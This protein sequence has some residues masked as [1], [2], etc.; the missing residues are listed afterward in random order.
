MRWIKRT[1]D[2]DDNDLTPLQR[3]VNKTRR[4]DSAASAELK[5][6][7]GRKCP[8]LWR[9]LGDQASMAREVVN[10]VVANGDPL[11]KESV[12][13]KADKLEKEL[14]GES[15]PPLLRS[16]ID[17]GKSQ[18]LELVLPIELAWKQLS[19]GNSD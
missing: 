2:Q 11:L 16:V 8:G 1:A 19:Q 13:R 14:A 18:L 3:L 10:K 12:Q 6:T 7:L 4:G 17:R 5:A 15:A 9:E